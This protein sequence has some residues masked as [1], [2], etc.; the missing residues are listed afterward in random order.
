VAEASSAGLAAPA[1]E[2]R[3]EITLADGVRITISGAVSVEQ[4][5]PVLSV[6]RR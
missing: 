4:L 3:I 2:G 1:G 5:H 6:L